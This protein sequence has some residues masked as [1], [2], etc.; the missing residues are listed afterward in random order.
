MSLSENCTNSKP[1]YCKE[2]TEWRYIDNQKIW[3][4]GYE[5]YLRSAKWCYNFENEPSRGHCEQS[6]LSQMIFGHLLITHGYNDFSINRNYMYVNGKDI[7][8]HFDLMNNPKECHEIGK[9]AAHDVSCNRDLWKNHVI[10]N[11][12]PV[13]WPEDLQKKHNNFGER[14][15]RLLNYCRSNWGE[16]EKNKKIDISFNE[17]MKR[18]CQHLYFERIFIDFKNK[19]GKNLSKI[20]S[21]EW[22]KLVQE[23]NYKIDMDTEN[24]MKIISFEGNIKEIVDNINYLI[25]A[26]GCCIL[27]IL[28]ESIKGKG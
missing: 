15:D 20:K 7:L 9:K 8:I 12:T 1:S 25:E 27:S 14:W 23:W 5:N 24:N 3:E 18:T 10:G 4:E 2:K 28:K 17:Y 11:F 22:R 6:F 13:P 19:Y 26:R 16:W 21:E